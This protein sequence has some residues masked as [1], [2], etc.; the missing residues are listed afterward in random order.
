MSLNLHYHNTF[1]DVKHAILG[2][3][4]AITVS[5]IQRGGFLSLRTFGLSIDQGS[6]ILPS[7]NGILSSGLWLLAKAAVCL[8]RRQQ[9][10]S[11]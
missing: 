8:E 4:Y 9:I 6:F 3:L 7:Y 10:E 2:M 11:R 1:I 5:G